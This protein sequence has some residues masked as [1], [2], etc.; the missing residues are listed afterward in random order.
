MIVFSASVARAQSGELPGGN[1][2]QETFE[3]GKGGPRQ[4]IVGTWMGITSTGVQS[5]TTFGFGGTVIYSVPGEVRTPPGLT[6]TSH[7]GVWRH[8]G[9]RRYG[10]TMWDIFYDQTTGQVLQYHQIR[11]ELTLDSDD[12]MSARAQVEFSIRKVR[13]CCRDRARSPTG[14][15]NTSRSIDVSAAHAGAR[16]SDVKWRALVNRGPAGKERTSGRHAQ[17]P[18]SDACPASELRFGTWSA[19]YLRRRRY[20]LAQRESRAEPG[21][22]RVAADVRRW[23]P[24]STVGKRPT[25][26]RPRAD[27]VVV[28][29]R[30]TATTAGYGSALLRSRQV[31]S[32]LAAGRPACRGSPNLE[33]VS[34]P[35]RCQCLPSGPRA[36]P[37]SLAPTGGAGSRRPC[38]R[39]RGTGVLENPPPSWCRRASEEAG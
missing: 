10:L 2:P 20:A 30:Q 4:A 22:C 36:T 23:P 3:H 18:S 28:G 9:G 34:S 6:H 39:R 8:L 29:Q 13:W 35:C 32:G 27:R 5:L 37:R 17:S 38:A 11:S 25:A 19:G 24:V 16:H 21:G 7:H 12:E 33:P 1:E 31:F 26:I 15:F 14:A